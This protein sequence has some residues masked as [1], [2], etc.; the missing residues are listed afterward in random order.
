MNTIKF[1]LAALCV[2]A[3][4]ALATTAFAE[5]DRYA[6]KVM[7]TTIEY[8]DKG[9]GYLHP[10]YGPREFDGVGECM[11]FGNALGE[12][13][14]ETDPEWRGVVL[15]LSPNGSQAWD[16]FVADNIDVYSQF[17]PPIYSK[18]NSI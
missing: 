10:I 3:F 13:I 9:E 7:L 17:F 2:F 11:W 4:T 6:G 5:P 15:C 1:T 14:M 16:E 8:N 18:S 12:Y